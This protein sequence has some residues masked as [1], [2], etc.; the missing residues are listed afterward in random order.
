MFDGI[1]RN[2][3]V[4]LVRISEGFE[5]KLKA[6]FKVIWLLN[7]TCLPSSFLVWILVNH[8]VLFGKILKIPQKLLIICSTDTPGSN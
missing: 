2:E 3:K 5:E 7:E 6:N 1:F 8:S 4:D